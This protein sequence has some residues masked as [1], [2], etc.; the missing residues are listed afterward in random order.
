MQLR[1]KPAWVEN[2]VDGL[3]VATR[4]KEEIKLISSS[5]TKGST[6]YKD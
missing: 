1:V 5:L 6:F 2:F 4:G 3:N